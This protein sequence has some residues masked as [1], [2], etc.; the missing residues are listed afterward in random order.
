M[1]APLPPSPRE[2]IL[3]AALQLLETGGAQAVSTRTVSAAAGVQPPT[4]YRHFGDMHGL[5]DTAASAGFT[6]FVQAK[7]ARAP[8]G[9]NN[10]VDQLR[11][12]WR[13]HVEFGLSRPHVYLQMLGTPRPGERALAAL[14]ATEMVRALMQRLAQAGRLAIGVDAAASMTLAA[15]MG[16]T[17][18]LLGSENQDAGLSERMLES[19]LKTILTPEAPPTQGDGPPSA[20]VFAVSL[21]AVLPE[22]Q[23]PFSEAEQ[24]LLLEWLQRLT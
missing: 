16:T 2:R 1:T 13:L 19:V 4:I 11:E 7:V 5:L 3:R 14:Q 23:S 9:G 12:G 21:A 18:S 8:I 17:L 20:A 15:V 10:P 24:R 22:L 6:A